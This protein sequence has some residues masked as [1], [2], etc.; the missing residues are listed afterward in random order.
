MGS[1]RKM[2]GGLPIRLIAMSSR[3]RIPP[4]Y[5]A[6]LRPAASV[7][8][9]RASRSSAIAPGFFRWRSWATRTR[10]SRPV[11]ISSTA[12]NWPVRLIDSRTSPGLAATSKP[13]TV[14]V[15]RIRLQQGREDAHEGGLAG[16]VGAEKGEDAA[17][18]DVEVDA[19]QHVQLLEGLLRPCTRMAVSPARCGHFCLLSSAF[20]IA[21]FRRARSL[22]IHWVPP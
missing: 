12:A 13:W 5:V 22:S 9:K 8:V 11:R 14:A 1:S 16:A 21:L 3:R 19:A 10:F 6:A 4:E 17:R 2:T 20:S 15:P 18:L 7:S